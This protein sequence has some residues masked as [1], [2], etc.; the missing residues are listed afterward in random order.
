MNGLD[1]ASIRL[2]TGLKLFIAAP[3]SEKAKA[4]FCFGALSMRRRLTGGL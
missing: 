4:G 2:E 3:A 1:T